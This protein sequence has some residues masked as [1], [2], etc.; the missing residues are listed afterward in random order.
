MRSPASQSQE[1]PSRAARVRV[2]AVC[3]AVYGVQSLVGAVQLFPQWLDAMRHH[4]YANVSFM[5]M[6]L[7]SAI[8]AL[9]AAYGLWRQRRWARIPT[10]VVVV[11][12]MTQLCLIAGFA[13]GDVGSA[14]VWLA[15][16]VL[17]LLA[18]VLAAW[19]VRYIWRHT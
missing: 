8:A 6:E 18:F 11:L 14:R 19:L 13:V 5:W 7:V 12:A 17:L 1:G 4:R 16:G 10:L 9:A 3:L 2:L 15:V